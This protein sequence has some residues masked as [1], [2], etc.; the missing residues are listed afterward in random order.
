MQT[1]LSQTRPTQYI[2]PAAIR[3]AEEGKNGCRK[4]GG[5]VF[6]LERIVSSKGSVYHKQCLKCDECKVR[7][8]S[9]LV[10]PYEDPGAR[11]NTVPKTVPKI[12]PKNPSK[13]TAKN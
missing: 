13:S 12:V 10:H 8:D 11:L 3:A 6:D 9:G 2:N 1:F 5:V 4:C 7:L